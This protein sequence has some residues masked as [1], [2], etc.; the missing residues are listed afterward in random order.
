MS[1]EQIKEENLDTPLPEVDLRT[2]IQNAVAKSKEDTVEP[3]DKPARKRAEDGKFAKE[4][5]IEEELVDVPL[6]PLVKPPAALSAEAKEK[7]N[8]LPD[9]AK[10][11]WVKREEETHKGFTRH[12]EDRQFGKSLKD[13]I[14]PYM[15]IISAEG[16]TPL[17]A[18]QD[19]LNTAYIL[20]TAPPQ[21]KSQLFAKLAN[22][23]G[24]D[25]G[26]LP[27]P[28]NINP[29]VQALQQQVQHL[30]GY[31]NQAQNTQKQQEQAQI[32]G[33]IN[34]FASD[35]KN[36]HFEAVKA[37]MAALLKEGLAEDLQDAY[38]QAVYARPDIRSTLLQSLQQDTEAKQIAEKKA[39]AEAARKASGSVTG[40]PGVSVPVNGTVSDRSLRDDL[41]ANL[42]A[43]QSRV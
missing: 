1:D 14:S 36:V 29:D 34:A 35:P 13:V 8:E 15:P 40:S 4:D 21:Q 5:K 25:L 31:I 7:F 6:E 9:W 26:Q 23:F 10:K 18:I 38:D 37:H 28:A 30:T 20:R 16:G 22:Q 19:L 3:E 17:T 42:R 39:K 43:V 2:E 32:D 41:R 12:D 11:E 33:Q 27:Q 24:V